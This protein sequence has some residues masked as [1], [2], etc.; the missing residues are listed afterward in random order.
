MSELCFSGYLSWVQLS[1]AAILSD[2]ATAETDKECYKN[3][4]CPLGVI[5]EFKIRRLLILR[6]CLVCVAWLT[7]WIEL[8]LE[9]AQENTTQSWSS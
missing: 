3:E 4:I 9:S 8:Q 7:D 1:M 2:G 6:I 5:L